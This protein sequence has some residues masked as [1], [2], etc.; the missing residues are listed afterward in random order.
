MYSTFFPLVEVSA[1]IMY[2]IIIIM[3]F[4][5]ASSS[6]GWLEGKGFKLPDK[7]NGQFYFMWSEGALKAD[8]SQ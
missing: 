2:I 6:K 7:G 4:T 1:L 3:N 8:S 5:F